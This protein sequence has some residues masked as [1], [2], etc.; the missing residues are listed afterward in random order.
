MKNKDEQLQSCT[1]LKTNA[2]HALRQSFKGSDPD[3]K[4]SLS[5]FINS[6]SSL[7]KGCRLLL[8]KDLRW[9]PCLNNQV[10]LYSL[11][12]VIN[13][14][15]WVFVIDCTIWVHLLTSS[16]I[17]PLLLLLLLLFL[18]VL[19]NLLYYISWICSCWHI[20]ENITTVSLS[21]LHMAK[22][23]INGLTS[24]H[25]SVRSACPISSR[26]KDRGMGPP[27]QL[28]WI[29]EAYSGLYCVLKTRCTLPSDKQLSSCHGYW[30]TDVEMLELSSESGSTE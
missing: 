17:L 18:P 13:C 30:P 26:I 22:G 3:L 1:S 5:A 12:F 15:I 7:V 28:V 8:I 29:L 27:L 24:L 20:S 19:P 25:L 16:V 6:F 4:L 10:L 21:L 11:M 23:G 14:T 9:L 2:L